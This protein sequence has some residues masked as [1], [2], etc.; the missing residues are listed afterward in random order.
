M[1]FCL[2][3]IFNDW[4]VC[5]AVSFHRPA[6]SEAHGYCCYV[7]C[8]NLA[9]QECLQTSMPDGSASVQRRQ[10]WCNLQ[11]VRLLEGFCSKVSERMDKI[12][13]INKAKANLIC[14]G[15]S[16]GVFC[17]R[18]TV[19]DVAG[20]ARWR[21]GMK[22]KSVNLQRLEYFFPRIKCF[23]ECEGRMQKEPAEI[24]PT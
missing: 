21:T 22:R 4:K 3:P 14:K 5:T 9:P 10:K 19:G 11:L 15:L 1:Y 24:T 16:G 17:V 18:K 6:C 13:W 23:F 8:Q 12:W 7:H 2:P 20:K